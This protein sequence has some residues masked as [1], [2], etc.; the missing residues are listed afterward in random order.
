MPVAMRESATHAGLSLTVMLCIVVA[1]AAASAACCGP[2]CVN[3]FAAEL[4]LNEFIHIYTDTSATHA[5]KLAHTHT[6]PYTHI[7]R[8]THTSS[9]SL[10]PTE[11]TR[12]IKTTNDHAEKWKET[13]QKTQLRSS[14]RLRVRCLSASV[15]MRVCLS[16]GKGREKN[17]K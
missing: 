14:K 10:S 17:N 2:C 11:T 5:H 13:K 15:C 8:G 3:C 7:D 1:A 6:H 9:L 16:V 4:T 12:S